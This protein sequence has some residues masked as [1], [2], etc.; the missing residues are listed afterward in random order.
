MARLHV[1]HPGESDHGLCATDLEGLVVQHGALLLALAHVITQNWE[2]AQDVVQSTYEIALRNL[3][4]LREPGAA[5][6]WLVRIESREA[7]RLRRRAGRFGSLGQHIDEL[8]DLS[9]TDSFADLRR[10]VSRLPPRTRAA[11]LLHHYS[12]LSVDETAHVLGVS[13]N[14]VRTQLRKG[15]ARIREELR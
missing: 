7:L 3:G 10:A 1:R 14:T 9:E 8:A 11:L 12:G 13:S 6:A 15:L 5:R 2:E 4:Q